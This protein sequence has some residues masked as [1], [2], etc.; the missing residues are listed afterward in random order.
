MSKASTEAIQRSYY[1]ATAVRYDEMHV[2]AGDEHY[3]SLSYVSALLRRLNAR[4]VLDLGCGTGRALLYLRHKNPEVMIY[5]VEPVVA[6]LHAAIGKGV[7][8]NL[9]VNGHGARLPFKDKSFDAVVECGVLH[10]VA[11]P[12][13]VV[14]EMA[15]VARQAIFLSDSNIFGQGRP[16][17]RVLKLLLYKAGFWRTAKFVQTRGRGYTLTDGDGLA[18]S[19]S[20]FFQ[21]RQ[22]REWAD[23][24]LAIPVSRQHKFLNAWSPV[25]AAS[26]VL[27][28]ALRE[29]G[30]LD[31]LA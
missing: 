27:L 19:Y 22:L 10:H 1:S 13:T 28:C 24:I 16:G 2:A 9:L 30:G 5:G 12:Q 3:V 15:R 25:L 11:K 31:L 20:V 14:S 26:G 6:L 4:T 8:T 21:Y 23:T 29:S 18:Y 17:I 7:S